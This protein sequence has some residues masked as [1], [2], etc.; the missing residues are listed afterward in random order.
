MINKKVLR[1]VVEEEK[2]EEEAETSNGKKRSK[3]KRD[4]T[5]EEPKDTIMGSNQL[6]GAALVASTIA[7]M[8]IDNT[9]LKSNGFPW[10]LC[11]LI[12]FTA[13]LLG[14]GAEYYSDAFL[15]ERFFIL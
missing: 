3:K 2:K 10:L 12:P 7:A 6:P 8:A 14:K 5:E 9:T 1:D 11:Y 4:E 15:N 13:V